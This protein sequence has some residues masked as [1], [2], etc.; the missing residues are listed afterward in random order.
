MARLPGIA[1]LLG[2]IYG[3]IYYTGALELF[4]TQVIF[5]LLRFALIKE[6]SSGILIAYFMHFSIK[7]FFLFQFC[8][9][10]SLIVFSLWPTDRSKLSVFAVY[11]FIIDNL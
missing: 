10:F 11:G 7:I 5:S 1:S 2:R 8:I 9:S 4:H 6:S 3:S